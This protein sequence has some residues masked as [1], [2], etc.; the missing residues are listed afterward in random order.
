MQ[1]VVN[2]CSTCGIQSNDM[3]LIY[4]HFILKNYKHGDSVLFLGYV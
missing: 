4:L 1:T 2:S 3:P